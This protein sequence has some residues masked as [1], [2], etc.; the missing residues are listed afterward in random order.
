MPISDTRHSRDYG[1]DTG[2]SL[3]ALEELLFS[4]RSIPEFF[5][6]YFDRKS[7]H[8]K[9]RPRDTFH[10]L[11]SWRDAEELLWQQAEHTS[12]FVQVFG[13]GSRP[14]PSNDPTRPLERREH[15][16][17]VYDQF[18]DGYST[19]LNSIGRYWLPIA[20]LEHRISGLITGVQPPRT[21]AYLSPPNALGL[22][23]HF[24]TNDVFI[25][26]V[27]GSKTWQ[28][29]DPGIE[30]PV[31]RHGAQPL[32]DTHKATRRTITLRAGDVLYLPRG[33]IHSAQTSDEASL[34]LTIG[35]NPLRWIDLFMA[36]TELAEEADIALRRSVE[37]PRQTVEAD[38]LRNEIARILQ[39][40]SGGRTTLDDVLSRVRTSL[41]VKLR[42]MPGRNLADPTPGQIELDTVVE[43]PPDL[44]CVVECEDVRAWIS[45]PRLSR[46][47]PARSHQPE[48]IAGP[49]FI[50]PSLR[51]VAEADAPFRIADLPGRM[52]D[53]SRVVL[54]TRLIREGL[55]R[56]CSDEA[57]AAPAAAAASGIEEPQSDFEALVLSP[58]SMAGF[59]ERYYG[60]G[61]LHIERRPPDIFRPLFSRQ[62]A[63]ELLW[64]HERQIP[65]MVDLLGVEGNPV[66]TEEISSLLFGGE[67][68]NW[69]YRLYQAGN[70]IR[71]NRIGEFWLPIA[72]LENELTKRFPG[73]R[74][75]ETD[76][77]L[78]SAQSREMVDQVGV[79]DVFVLQIAGWTTWYFSDA[80]GNLRGES[81][82][83]SSQ[84]L[85]HGSV[86]GSVS[87]RPGQ[88]LYLPRDT[89]YRNRAGEEGSIH[90]AIAIHPLRWS[91]LLSASLEMA[92]E[93]DVALR[94]SV[95]SGH[96]ADKTG[97]IR[98][99][100]E[101]LLR[102]HRC[103]DATLETVMSRA[104][105][106]LADR[107]LPLP[108]GLFESRK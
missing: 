97:E 74:P 82:P 67:Y 2:S 96:A 57:D 92:A 76:A 54:V 10:S 55:L 73:L 53:K 49:A 77:F 14:S 16:E 22:N 103:T 35:F 69:I 39:R 101:A 21:I 66:S 75:A 61:I 90:L 1:N 40:H 50:E 86:N 84:K 45:F 23:E 59:V 4:P 51:F 24:D 32:G 100:L 36:A 30:L 26:Q 78:V 98:E 107:V 95:L 42:S 8:I 108:T 102:D 47:N 3:S 62:I 72:R 43:R 20:Q 29:S 79:N 70:I 27:E 44:L 81:R 80:S 6:I 38:R 93:S 63:E 48:I 94:R 89:A 87:L 68:R 46:R 83:A 58:M 106:S 28:I 60:Q 5:E 7:L 64:Q 71:W 31:L 104:K 56:K 65:E 37:P 34:H 12:K 11:F 52:S 17:W 85:S 25:L 15:R 18:Q 105:R 88:V 41:V 99:Q 9:D 91:E 19:R 33:V 13:G